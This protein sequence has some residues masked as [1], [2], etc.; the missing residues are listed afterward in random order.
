MRKSPTNN[1]VIDPSTIVDP[2]VSTF[3][4]ATKTPNVVVGLI[5]QG[6]QYFYPYQNPNITPLP[7]PYTATTVFEIGSITKAFTATML[8]YKCGYGEMS[9]L[10]PVT[11]YLPYTF[12]PNAGLKNVTIFQLATHTSGMLD[13]LAGKPAKELF[14]GDLPAKHL[15]KFWQGFNPPAPPAGGACWRYSNIGYVTLGFAVG[16]CNPN[17][18]N[19]LLKMY[20]TDELNMTQTGSTDPQGLTVA[21][22]YVGNATTNTPIPV[23]QEADD[24]KSTAQD[25]TKFLSACIN[26]FQKSIPGGLGT[27]LMYAQN[28]ILI[29]T[30]N[31]CGKTKPITFQQGLAWQKSQLTSHNINYSLLAKDGAT[32]VGGFQSW[33]GFIPSIMGIVL[34][35]NKCMTT[36]TVPPQSLAKAGRTILQA[37][38]DANVGA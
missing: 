10:D 24:L 30:P 37:L 28:H 22:G 27:G 34:L 9:L 20:I 33:I 7:P 12:A 16:G 35:G 2:A 17:N 6:Q 4:S 18:Y 3:Q 8:G 13:T 11:K 23:N 26:P 38:L 14:G 19:S 31:E 36:P 29:P 21:Q 5:C 25:M 15:I 32:S 1:P